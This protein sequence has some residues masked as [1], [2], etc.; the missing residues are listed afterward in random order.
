VGHAN[1]W[2]G[3]TAGKAQLSG[4]GFNRLGESTGLASA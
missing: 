4:Q 1:R 2:M 3:C